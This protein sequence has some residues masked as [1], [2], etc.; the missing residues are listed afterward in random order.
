MI[1]SSLPSPHTKVDFPYPWGMGPYYAYPSKKYKIDVNEVFDTN[2]DEQSLIKKT[3]VETYTKQKDTW[4][5]IFDSRLKSK[6]GSDYYKFK[7]FR[8]FAGDDDPNRGPDFLPALRKA[9]KLYLPAL[10]DLT[11]YNLITGEDL[12]L[13][14]RL[15]DLWDLP[16]R[17][18][19]INQKDMNELEEQQ[20][21]F[22]KKRR[23]NIQKFK[24]N[25]FHI[26][27]IK[28]SR[29]EEPVP[30]DETDVPDIVINEFDLALEKLYGVNLTTIEPYIVDIDLIESNSKDDQQPIIDIREWIKERLTEN[31]FTPVTQ[32]DLAYAELKKPQEDNNLLTHVIGNKH[33][34]LLQ[35]AWAYSP[36]KKNPSINFLDAASTALNL[37]RI[38]DAPL[39]E[40]GNYNPI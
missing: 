1:T 10:W 5:N 2:Y 20:K 16:N 35:L 29:I 27:R 18:G 30:L 21:N 3:L 34:A 6:E 17:T 8:Y 28:K 12:P 39:D 36:D 22:I 33:Y 32:F 19:Q 31:P 25:P 26:S 7:L 13:G 37:M 38:F 15:H 24:Y 11:T 4:A 14:D 9:Y 40:N 23:A